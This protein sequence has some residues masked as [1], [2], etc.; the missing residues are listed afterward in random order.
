MTPEAVTLMFI[1]PLVLFKGLKFW[2]IISLK[3]KEAF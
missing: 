1:L 3:T 2:L